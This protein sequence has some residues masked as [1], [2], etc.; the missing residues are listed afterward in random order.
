MAAV[1]GRPPETRPGPVTLR[2]PVRSE[3]LRLALGAAL[4]EAAQDALATVTGPAAGRPPRPTATGGP[5]SQPGS[6][7]RR[8][9]PAPA[10]GLL[11]ATNLN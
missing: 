5:Q 10:S 8:A 7:A 11:N 3:A 9:E 4:T 1:P 6:R 2:R